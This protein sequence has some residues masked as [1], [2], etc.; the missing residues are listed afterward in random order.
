MMHIDRRSVVALACSLLAMSAAAAA[1]TST[2][3]PKSTLLLSS[4]SVKHQV[5]ASKREQVGQAPAALRFEP[6]TKIIS[7]EVLKNIVQQ[8]LS[9]S[10][11]NS[12]RQLDEVMIEVRV[13]PGVAEPPVQSQ[14]PFGFAAIAWGIRHPD[15]AWRLVL[16]VLS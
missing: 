3:Q 2:W 1:D 14:I 10:Q 15:Q 8:S 12:T 16:P 5:D 7:P 6:A 9:L 11:G 13:P 4:K